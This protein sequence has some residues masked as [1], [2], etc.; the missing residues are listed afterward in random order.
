MKPRLLVVEDERTIR[1]I[2]TTLLGDAGYEVLA[3]ESGEEALERAPAFRPELALLDLQLGGIS[4]VQTMTELQSRLGPAPP[5]FVI[6]TAHGTIRSAVEAMRRGAADYVTKPFDNDELQLVLQ[7]ALEVRMLER[8]VEALESQLDERFRPENM[9][10]QSGAM[11]AVFRMVGRIAPVDT[12]VLLTGESGTGRELVARAVHRHSGRSDGPFIAVNCGAVPAALLETTFFG[13]EQ[14]AFTDAKVARRGAFEQAGGGTLFLDEVGELSGAAQAGLLRVLQ[15]REIRRVGGETTIPVDVRVV[16]ATNR[17]LADEV[18]QGRF[19]EDLF[20]RRNVV[21]LHLPPLRERREDVPPLAEHFVAKHAARL[22]LPPRPIHP[23]ALALL[24]GYEWPGNVRELENAME[25]ALILGAEPA[26]GV[27]DLPPR[28]RALEPGAEQDT[29]GGAEGDGV[30]GPTLG[31]A[32]TRAQA[33]L[34]R[35]MIREVLRQTGGNRTRAAERLGISRK[36]LFNKM[37]ELE[38]EG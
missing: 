37:H 33:G 38:I 27:A 26:L 28:I 13:H 34:E 30:P 23:D 17:D 11:D 21:A 10:G 2:L 20:W 36:T 19:R 1:R 3:V 8:R 15:E 32:V 12:T 29:D 18:R 24:V 7:R 22:G 6:M 4:G 14:G 9:V 31:E 16:A 35:Q 25:R 5:A